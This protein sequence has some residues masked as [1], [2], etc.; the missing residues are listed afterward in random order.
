MGHYKGEGEYDVC[1]SFIGSCESGNSYGFRN[2]WYVFDYCCASD[3]CALEDLYESRKA[4]GGSLIPFY[5][6]YLVFDIVYGKGWKFLW[7]IVPIVNIYYAIVV[8]FKMAKVFGKGF[9]WIGYVF[10]ITDL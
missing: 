8:P 3:H 1:L 7:L 5:N 9:I 2:L 10:I 4:G 6:L